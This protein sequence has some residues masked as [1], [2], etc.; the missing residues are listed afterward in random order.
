MIKTILLFFAKRLYLGRVICSVVII[1]SN[2]YRD[3]PSLH[4]IVVKE[5]GDYLYVDFT[6][7]L[8]KIKNLDP[9]Y[10]KVQKLNNNSCLYEK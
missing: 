3:N 1:L 4:G 9:Y 6:K 5:R 8:K 7:E 2:G 10:N